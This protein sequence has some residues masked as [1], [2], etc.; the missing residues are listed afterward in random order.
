MSCFQRLT[1]LDTISSTSFF[2]KPAIDPETVDDVKDLASGQ[3]SQLSLLIEMRFSNTRS[4]PILPWCQM[5]NLP[6]TSKNAS[7]I[8]NPGLSTASATAPP[9]DHLSAGL[10]PRI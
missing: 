9:T 4:G 7:D 5:H 3:L 8:F 6:K 1:V 2:G 10:R